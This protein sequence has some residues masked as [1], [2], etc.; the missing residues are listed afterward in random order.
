[1]KICYLETPKVN[2]NESILLN[3]SPYSKSLG[4][5]LTAYVVKHKLL[6]VIYEDLRKLA[7]RQ[8]CFP[9]TYVRLQAHCAH[10]SLRA[11]GMLGPP[12]LLLTWQT[13]SSLK[14][15]L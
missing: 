3:L 8:R 9:P 5:P 15:K 6:S 14:T 13:P 10:A 2:I 1:M 11:T 7:R 4:G 12:P